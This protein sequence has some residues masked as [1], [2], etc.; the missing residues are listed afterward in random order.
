MIRKSVSSCAIHVFENVWN[1]LENYLVQ[2]GY[3]DG[4][5]DCI[6]GCYESGWNER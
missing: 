4:E 2:T 1:K 5:I 6:G 3:S